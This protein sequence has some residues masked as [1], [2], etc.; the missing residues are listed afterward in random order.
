[1]DSTLLHRQFGK[2]T[3]APVVYLTALMELFFLFR[4]V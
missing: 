2:S 3:I 1:M 4:S